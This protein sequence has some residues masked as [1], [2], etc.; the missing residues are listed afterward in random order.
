MTP[1]RPTVSAVMISNAWRFMS[2]LLGMNRAD[3]LAAAYSLS[4]AV[5]KRRNE[6]AS[7]LAIPMPSGKASAGCLDLVYS[8]CIGCS[9]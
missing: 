7:Q 8:N 3:I 6:V 1:V 9:G 2:Q 4:S 5:S